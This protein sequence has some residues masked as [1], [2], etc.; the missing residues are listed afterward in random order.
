MEL[1]KFVKEKRNSVH[2][3]QPELAE[4]A[5]YDLLA[6]I[7]VNPKDNEDMALLQL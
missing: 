5:G 2:L 7:L 6:T 4:K 1:A 3:I